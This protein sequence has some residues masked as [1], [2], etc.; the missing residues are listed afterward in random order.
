FY[1]LNDPN[2]AR[3]GF[4]L[5]PET[6][7]PPIIS[8]LKITYTGSKTGGQ[9]VMRGYNNFVFDL[10]VPGMPDPV[11]ETTTVALKPFRTV[12]ETVVG[13]KAFRHSGESGGGG[14]QEPQVFFCFH[15]PRGKGFDAKRN[16]SLFQPGRAALR[17][18]PSHIDRTV[19]AGV[20]V[21]GRLALEQA[22]RG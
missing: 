13:V 3:K 2:D 1:T 10:P 22:G 19:G 5:T 21:L 11:S 12:D 4:F 16:K 7:A 14:R 15:S 8:S 17:R 18:R 9:E 6:F 20:G